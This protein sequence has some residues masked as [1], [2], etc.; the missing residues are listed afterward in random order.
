MKRKAE[1]ADLDAA[2]SASAADNRILL[3]VSVPDGVYDNHWYTA[4]LNET[5]SISVKHLCGMPKSIPQYGASVRVGS[6][7]CYIGG[8]FFLEDTEPWMQVVPTNSSDVHLFDTR[9]PL[10]GWRRVGSMAAA[11]SRPGAV[12]INGKVYVFGGHCSASEPFGEVYDPSSDTWATLP[13]PPNGIN[14]RD[15]FLTRSSL[16][17]DFIIVHSGLEFYAFH[18]RSMSWPLSLG[19]HFDVCF[20][21]VFMDNVIYSYHDDDETSEDKALLWAF[22]LDETG[23]SA[24]LKKSLVNFESKLPAP[25]TF[26]VAL[27]NGNLCMLRHGTLRSRGTWPPGGTFVLQQLKVFIDDSN[28]LLRAEE[29][30]FGSFSIKQCRE[31]LD[32]LVL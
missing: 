24:T 28:G 7:I 17:N 10:N 19:E 23:P 12:S 30:F 27:R 1:K 13:D 22:Q 20:P 5:S 4:N 11:R 2:S 18:P 14:L 29:D 15:S 25:K 16:D 6:S 32:V 31:L 3:H 26:L 9:Y 21:D 8:K